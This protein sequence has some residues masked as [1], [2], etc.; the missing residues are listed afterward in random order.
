MSDLPDYSHLPME[1]AH[2]LL[3]Y[4]GQLY[5]AEAVVAD[6]RRRIEKFSEVDQPVPTRLKNR[7]MHWEGRVDQ[8]QDMI[9]R[10]FADA[11][12]G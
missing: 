6:L 1:A 8:L 5:G 12:E 7:L 11:A 10:L 4:E 2:T 3:R 9:T